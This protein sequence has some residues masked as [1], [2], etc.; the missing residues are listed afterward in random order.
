MTQF[1]TRVD[2]QLAEAVDRLIEDGSIDS[3]SEAVR[4]GLRLVVDQLQ[5]RRVAQAI[6]TGYMET[7][8]TEMEMGWSDRATASMIAEE[9]W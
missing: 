8:Q 5:R 4:R 3:R 9:T 1:V 2:D 7:P 6:V